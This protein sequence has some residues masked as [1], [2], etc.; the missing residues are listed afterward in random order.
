MTILKKDSSSKASE[1]NGDA[2]YCYDKQEYIGKG[3]ND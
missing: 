2:L 3:R 1:K